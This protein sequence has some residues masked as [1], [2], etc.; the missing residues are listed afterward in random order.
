[1]AGTRNRQERNKTER[2]KI[3]GKL[4]F[5]TTGISKA[6][7]IFSRCNIPTET[8]GKNRQIIKILEENYRMKMGK[9]RK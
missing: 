5:E 8:I 7:Q 2:R 1:M 3:Q 9:G 6:T 4:G